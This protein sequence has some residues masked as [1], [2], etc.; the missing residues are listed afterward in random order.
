METELLVQNAYRR[1]RER[2]NRFSRKLRDSFLLSAFQ[3]MKIDP[4]EIEND[5]NNLITWQEK[6]GIGAREK[7]ILDAISNIGIEAQFHHERL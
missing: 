4:A 5:I 1:M 2:E 7:E 3:F 6:S